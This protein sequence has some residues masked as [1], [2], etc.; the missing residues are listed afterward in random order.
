MTALEVSLRQGT[1]F[2]T[3]VFGLAYAA[4]TAMNGVYKTDAGQG[5]AAALHIPANRTAAVHFGKMDA[6]I[7]AST[8]FGLLGIGFLLSLVLL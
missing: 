6:V 1:E 3:P 5:G 7:I 4:I 8:L 2:E